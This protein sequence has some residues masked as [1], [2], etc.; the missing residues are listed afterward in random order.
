M[1]YAELANKGILTQPVYEPGKPIDQVARELGLDP[2][3]IVKLASNENPFGPS[4]RAVAAGEK[5][6]REANLYPDGGYYVLRERLA[7]H[8][9]LGMDQFVIGDGSNEILEL[10]GHAFLAPGVECVMPQASFIVYKLVTLMFGAT[11]V[12][13]PLA[14]GLK[15]DLAA[16]RAAVTPRT[17]LVFLASPANPVGATNTAEEIFALVRSLPEHVIFVFD[18]AYA[19]FLENP[20]DLR[21]LIAEG[22]KVI[23]LRTFS[24]IYGLAALRVG[25]GYAAKE[26]IAIVQRARQPFNV[27]AIA[28]AMAV[29]ALDDAEFVAMVRRE[30]RAGLAQLG[31]GFR[32]LG[33][34]FVPGQ[35]NFL[36]VKV[37]D[38]GAV[39]DALQ[40]RGLITRPVKPYGLPEWLRVSVGTREQNA[41]LLDTLANV[42]GRS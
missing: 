33:L 39:F 34:E 27:S 31:E 15:Q 11:P 6:L 14:P 36:L 12:E 35:G 29:A 18:E 9:G 1:T 17:R 13:V 23:G 3:T 37:G 20:P 24:K 28:A 42:L 26:L 8:W 25:Y 5:A 30:N 7:R 4:P 40:R 16:L 19:E 41:R 32:K 21:V 22:R 38:G 10:L 2:A